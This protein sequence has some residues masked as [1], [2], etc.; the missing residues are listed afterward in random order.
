MTHLSMNE[1]GGSYD[2]RPYQIL[3]TKKC[4]TPDMAR[5]TEWS[6]WGACSKN[7]AGTSQESEG[8][9]SRTRECKGGNVGDVG[10]HDSYTTKV[11]ERCAM[12]PCDYQPNRCTLNV[13]HIDWSKFRLAHNSHSIKEH[14]TDQ[15]EFWA[16]QGNTR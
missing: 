2:V 9:R 6:R 5:W 7:C 3:S 12:M 13:D 8:F 14:E 11:S 4:R 1:D 16:S 15:T 10:C